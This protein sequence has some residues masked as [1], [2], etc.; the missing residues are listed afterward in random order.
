MREIHL[1]IDIETLGTSPNAHILSIGVLAF[2]VDGPIEWERWD[3]I[4]NSCKGFDISPETV[5]WWLE[6]SETARNGVIYGV[7]DR[8]KQHIRSALIGLCGFVR[9]WSCDSEKVFIWANSPSFDIVIIEN[10]MKK[11]DIKPP[12]IYRHL[13]DLRTL[14][15]T[16]ENM[17]GT[18]PDFTG[19]TREYLG[20][21]SSE[22]D[23]IYDCIIQSFA[24]SHV[25]GKKN[26]YITS[27]IEVSNGEKNGN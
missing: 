4:P 11:F 1:M 27:N 13:M 23:P 2:S 9:K 3:I 5:L 16:W 10:A 17:G 6:Q 25:W 21:S 8:P 18:I 15:R 12:W 24:V 26:I 22:H 14:K 7:P 20:A 19:K